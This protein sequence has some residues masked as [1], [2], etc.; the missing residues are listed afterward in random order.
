MNRKV[1]DRKIEAVRMRKPDTVVDTIIIHA[2]SEYIVNE[3]ETMFCVDFL[4]EIQYGAHYFILPDG[5]IFEGVIPLNR[6]PHVGRSEYYNRKWLNETS[7]GIEFLVDGVNDY[8]TF[9]QRINAR[10][11]K[12]H[13]PP[14]TDDQYKAGAQLILDLQDQFGS[15][16]GRI[17]GHSE[18]SGDDVRGEGR[19]KRDPGKNFNW[20][21]LRSYLK[22][23][24]DTRYDGVE[25]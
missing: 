5:T 25:R 19:G 4:N 16:L 2:M 10:Q 3:G 12:K 14:F 7:I 18:V 9:I 11:S 6:T 21:E 15:I 23:L 13:R 17:V 24:T 8:A 1:R 22:K 20:V